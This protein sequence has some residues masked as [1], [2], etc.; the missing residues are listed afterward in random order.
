L[1]VVYALLRC[2]R[3]DGMLIVFS[4]VPPVIAASIVDPDFLNLYRLGSAVP[5]LYLALVLFFCWCRQVTNALPGG[6][7]IGLL[8]LV[9]VGCASSVMNVRAIAGHVGNNSYY[10]EHTDFFTNIRSDDV[11]IADTVNSL[12]SKHA[13][14]LVTHY[15]GFDEPV[16]LPWLYQQTPPLM[17]NARTGNMD[18][19]T[20]Q[21]M[22][23]SPPVQ[24]GPKYA[25]FW[26]P[27]LGV[28]QTGM[29]YIMF[30]DDK[31]ALLPR[32]LRDYPGGRLRTIGFD[33]CATT[34]SLTVYTLSVKQLEPNPMDSQ[35]P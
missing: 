17:Y 14:F 30:N 9:L 6:T 5:G 29:S 24:V 22:P 8:V 12:G 28:G 3:L 33:S 11:L 31:D 4:I 15:R 21:L 1:A 26:P 7:Q 13:D 35:H 10:C 19:A 27:H 32:L 20:W 16:A 18:P 23:Y 25:T 34:Y 2:G